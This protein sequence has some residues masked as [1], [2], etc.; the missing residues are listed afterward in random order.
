MSGVQKVIGENKKQNIALSCF[1][2][3]ADSA[4]HN[5]FGVSHSPAMFP[6]ATTRLSKWLE[7]V[8]DAILFSLFHGI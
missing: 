8:K 1:S 3:S 7:T 4:S 5:E 6:S 2:Y